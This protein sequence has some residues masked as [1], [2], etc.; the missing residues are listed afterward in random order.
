MAFLLA[1]ILCGAAVVAV[2]IIHQNWLR[3]HTRHWV[4]TT[5]EV[6]KFIDGGDGSDTYLLQYS[7][8][9]EVYRIETSPWLFPLGAAKAGSIITV[10]VNPKAP[11]ECAGKL[12]QG[13]GFRWFGAGSR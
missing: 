12:P 11:R 1:F 6:L 4:P 10:L 7:F 13:G 2:A 9:G 8:D 5:A 3:D